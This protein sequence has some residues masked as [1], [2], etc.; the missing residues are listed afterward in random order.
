M[1]EV[2]AQQADSR[3][4]MRAFLQIW[5]ESLSQVLGQISGATVACD[6]LA[7]APG[8]LPPAAETDVWAVI[9]CSGGLRGEMSLRLASASAIRLAQIFVGETPAAQATTDESGSTP[10]SADT[11]AANLSDEQRE[12][13]IELLRQIGGVSSSAKERWGEVQLGIELAPSAPSWPAAATFWLQAG[14]DRSR[15]VLEAGL[16]AALAA[17]LKAEK[18]EAAKPVA[19]PPA[20]PTANAVSAANASKPPDAAV[21]A[22]DDAQGTDGLDALM[23]VQLSMTLRFGSKTMLLRDVLDLSPGA[24]VELDRKVQE[25]VDLLLE[26][27]LVARGDLVVIDGNYGLRVT[28][29]SLGSAGAQQ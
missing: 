2:A 28:Y 9:A 13:V 16:S 23:D 29:V 22:E 15:I 24:V 6:V 1:T 7:E 18:A 14:E 8:D 19:Y 12:A 4:A 10:P 25:P 27:K 3:D 11:P 20:S 21:P 17:E 26:G 5:A